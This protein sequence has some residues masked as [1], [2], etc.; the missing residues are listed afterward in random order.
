MKKEVICSLRK[1][2]S[3]P[4]P[5]KKRL[6]RSYLVVITIPIAILATLITGLFAYFMINNTIH[7]AQRSN[8][9]ILK[10]IDNSFNSL[11]LLSSYTALDPNIIGVL[12][13][14]Y[15]SYGTKAQW[16]QIH[17]ATTLNSDLYIHIFYMNGS[18]SSVCLIPE[19]T[20]Y[21]YNAMLGDRYQMYDYKSTWWYK[22][23]IKANGR[24]VVI[25]KHIDY[26]NTL[27][28]SSITVGRCIVDPM[29]NKLLGVVLI[30]VYESK[31]T[32][33]WKDINIT[34]HS[35]TVATDENNQVIH[36]QNSV[37][38]DTDIQRISRDLTQKKHTGS[39]YY[40][41]LSHKAF[42]V[43]RSEQGQYQWHT[44]SVIPVVELFSSVAAILLAIVFSGFL[45]A[46]ILILVSAKIAKNI[47]QP[48]DCLKD[49]I[50]T[51]EQGDLTIQAVEGEDEI[52]I[53]AK[54]VNQMTSTIRELI[55]QIHREEKEKRNAELL[56]LQSQINP[57]FLYNTLNSIK[58]MAKIQGASGITNTLES[59]IAFLVFC[60]KN[61]E[62]LITLSEEAQIAQSYVDIM[63]LRY[64]NKITYR[65]DIP[66][67]FANCQT[68]RFLLQPMIE[69]AFLHGYASSTN[70]MISVSAFQQEGFLILR[71]ADNG[72][73]IE[74][75]RIPAILDGSLEAEKN[76]TTS[77]GLYNINQRIKMMLGKEYGIHIRSRLGFYTV[78]DTKLPFSTVEEEVSP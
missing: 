13:K 3:A 1:L 58:M 19:N 73:G 75:E 50:E 56:A 21:I 4:L 54:S 28:A 55:S 46:I 5:L 47:T 63:N 36:Q 29:N 78:I 11:V 22:R 34:P 77:I 6:I 51:I 49:T 9:Q 12:Q 68:I 44:V 7:V 64:L 45:M 27:K 59:L 38:S 31:I 23:I 53:L 71:V 32:E 33:L 72:M 18:I 10:N 30:N 16:E 14:N 62:E 20:S 60:T 25:G 17:D 40:T 52:G 66:E 24:V 48:I 15:K 70:G 76:R 57:H 42:L 37:A 74:S 35:F 43:I 39:I 65:C 26:M 69:N 41:W 8:E 67:A 61:R 2:N